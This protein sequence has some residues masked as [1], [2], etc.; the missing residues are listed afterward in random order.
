MKRCC[1]VLIATRFYITKSVQQ[2][3]INSSSS[4]TFVS[5]SFSSSNSSSS[6]A[7]A[8]LVDTRLE[9]ARL[10]RITRRRASPQSLR[11]RLDR[12]LQTCC[13]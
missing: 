13:S 4:N 9:D 11:L 3:D 2:T 6:F 5:G 10:A 12:S 8:A 7:A 1:V